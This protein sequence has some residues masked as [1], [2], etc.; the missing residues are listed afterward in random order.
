MDSSAWDTRYA[1]RE[2]VWTSE[3]N[4]FLVHETEG[5]APGRALDLACGEGRNAVWL[6]GRGWEMTGVDFSKVGLEKASRFADARGVHAEWIAADLVHY[7]PDLRAFDLVLIFYLQVPE[8]QR[9]PIVR[10]AADAVAAGGVFLLVGHDRTNVEEGHGGPQNP[11]VLYTAQ[12][13]VADLDYS[14][15]LIERAA[16]VDRPV[17]TP[18]GARVARDTLV[19]ARRA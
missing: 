1:E 7:R 6:A 9:Q 13:I 15:L 19:R 8:A 18:D 3:P 10:A 5:L 17:A 14:E 11:D 2:F 16:R 12:D 4:R